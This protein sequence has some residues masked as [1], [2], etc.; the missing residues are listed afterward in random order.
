MPTP[1]HFRR[2]FLSDPTND[3]SLCSRFASQAGQIA[4]SSGRMAVA[5]FDR[6]A[7]FNRRFQLTDRVGH[8]STSDDLC[9][10]RV[11]CLLHR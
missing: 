4:R 1:S 6:T 2:R 7:M 11:Y 9:A 10:G 8:P 3:E 5:A